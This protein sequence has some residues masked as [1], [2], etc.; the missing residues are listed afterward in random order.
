MA[1]MKFHLNEEELVVKK[2]DWILVTGAGGF[3]GG[4]DVH[5]LLKYGFSNLR[6][7]VRPA[8]DRRGLEDVILAHGVDGPEI[9][10]G[11]LLSPHAC[12]RAVEAVSVIYHLAASTD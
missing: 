3:I 1:V 12:D 2:S 4:R 10:E 5:M 9:V 6:C 11:N 8:G 7:L